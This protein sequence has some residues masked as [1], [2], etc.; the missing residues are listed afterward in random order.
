MQHKPKPGKFI[1][2]LLFLSVLLLSICSL[3]WILSMG[4]GADGSRYYADIYS[5]GKQ[6]D[7]IPLWQVSTPYTLQIVSENGG[8][9]ELLISRGEIS[10]TDATCPDQICVQQGSRSDSALPIVC[11]PNRLVIQ[12]REAADEDEFL[13][14]VTH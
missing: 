12:L 10:V 7:S 13:D 1:P 5:E 14:I 4:K 8:K 2:A 3:L 11:L 6:L 9:N